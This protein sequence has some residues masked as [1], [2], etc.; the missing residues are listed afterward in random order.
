MQ[1]IGE[2][3]APP[4][5]PLL[6]LCYTLMPLLN[7]TSLALSLPATTQ[8]D[9]KSLKRELLYLRL[10][11]LPRKKP[12]SNTWREEGAILTK[13][14]RR[15]AP[16]PTAE[17]VRGQLLV[18]RCYLSMYKHLLERESQTLLVRQLISSSTQLDRN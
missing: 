11:I 14:L 5:H 2:A 1:N 13:L 17:E 12:V 10:S 6:R 8:L 15:C 9:Y 7:N 16:G 18:E 4:P 3:I